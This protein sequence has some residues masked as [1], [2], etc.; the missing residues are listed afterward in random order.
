MIVLS[1]YKDKEIFRGNVELVSHGID[2]QTGRVV[3]MPNEPLAYYIEAGLAIRNHD[4]ECWVY[5]EEM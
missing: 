1:T 2:L 5:K 3:I 4:L